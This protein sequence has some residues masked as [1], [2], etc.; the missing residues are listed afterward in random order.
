[1]DHTEEPRL[2]VELSHWNRLT[3][4]R[5]ELRII[6]AECEDRTYVA[7]CPCGSFVLEAGGL[8][9]LSWSYRKHLNDPSVPADA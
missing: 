9:F 3:E 4:A 1:M 8:D 2:F 7:Y 6:R 5:H